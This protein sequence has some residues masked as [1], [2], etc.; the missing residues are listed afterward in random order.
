MNFRDQSLE[1]LERL[2]KEAKKGRQ[3][4]R[5]QIARMSK[6]RMYDYKLDC[7]REQKLSI[8]HRERIKEIQSEIDTR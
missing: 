4:Y 6:G 1:T 8:Y 7:S 5:M 3:Y 2:L